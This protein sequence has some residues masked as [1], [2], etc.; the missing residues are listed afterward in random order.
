VRLFFLAHVSEEKT[1]EN[2]V[3]PVDAIALAKDVTQQLEAQG[4]HAVLPEKPDI[5]I[6][7]KYGRGF[8]SNPYTSTDTDKQYTTLSDSGGMQVWTT[9]EKFVGLNE[10]A[11]R[12]K[13]EKL[14]IQVRAWEYPPP[15]DPKKKEKSCFG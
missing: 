2:L 13:Y 1:G 8:L 14:I 6:T 4:F 7:V 10:R 15:K 11:A 3:R 5:V 9:H 12:M